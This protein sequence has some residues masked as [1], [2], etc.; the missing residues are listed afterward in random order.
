MYIVCLAARVIKK[1]STGSSSLVR[2][3]S[4]NDELFV[5]L[6]R[7]F[8]QVAVYSINDYRHLR[9]LTVFEYRPDSRVEVTIHYEIST[10][11]L[12]HVLQCTSVP[13]LRC[14]TVR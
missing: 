13:M 12:L 10:V 3:T 1:I 7:N 4:V 2:V 8:D 11:L 14:I 6:K 9:H 5:L